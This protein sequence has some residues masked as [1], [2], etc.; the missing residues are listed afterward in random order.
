MEPSVIP[1]NEF[2]PAILEAEKRPI[3]ISQVEVIDHTE[4]FRPD[5]LSLGSPGTMTV[6]VGRKGT[7]AIEDVRAALTGQ[8]DIDK[9]LFKLRRFVLASTDRALVE[10]MLQQPV[11]ADIR[12]G[13]DVLNKGIFLPNGFDLVL[14]VFPYNGGRLARDGFSP[15][16]A[17]YGRFR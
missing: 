11:F 9:V 2:L 14:S 15:G 6:F 5:T 13:G 8:G 4:Q 1:S 3:R 16:G 17:L 7:G 10:M 12:Y